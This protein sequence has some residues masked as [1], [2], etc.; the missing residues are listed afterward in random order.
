MKTLL[1]S[2]MLAVSSMSIHAQTLIATSSNPQATANQNQRKIVRDGSDN[3]YVVFEDTYNQ[4]NII[5]GVM[6]SMIDDQWSTPATIRNGSNPTLSISEDGKIHL[7]YETNDSLPVIRYTYS[8]DFLT[9]TQDIF[10]SDPSHGC[11][12]PVSDVDSAGKVNVFWIRTNDSVSKSLLYAAIIGDSISETKT[13][14][15]RNDITNVAM[16][17]HLQNCDNTLF[18][19]VCTDPDSVRFFVSTDNMNTYN[20]IYAD[21]GSQPCISYNSY[22]QDWEPDLVRF[23]YI[24]PSTYPSSGL[25][26]IAGTAS[27]DSGFYYFDERTLQDGIVDYVCIDDLAP[28]IGYSYLFMKNGILYHG[29]SYF[30]DTRQSTIMGSVTTNPLNP[31]IDYKAFN[32]YFV[33]YIWME[34][35]GTSYNIF[36]RRDAKHMWIDAVDN[37]RGK[38]FTITGSPNPF[39]SLLAINVTVKDQKTIPE[40]QI[41]NSKS[42]MINSP[43]GKFSSPGT[44]SF[45][46]DGTDQSGN[47]V[48]S[49]VYLILCMAGDQRTARKVVYI[50]K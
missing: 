28:P 49:G 4:E 19:A 46:W 27:E 29:W 22:E 48:A 30:P 17:N 41:Y 33:D 47:K 24:S 10:V 43:E 34:H 18:F 21:E 45:S 20:S 8:S 32:F 42:H 16:A 3:I 31:S 11:R 44:Y 15:T 12:L 9:W 1:I 50:C 26:E 25:I 39:S 35:N 6:Y 36:Y 38:N 7:L 2:L 13:V 40:I 23:L 14:M 37:E 5:K